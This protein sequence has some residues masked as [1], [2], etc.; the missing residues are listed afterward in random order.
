MATQTTRLTVEEFHRRYDGLKPAFEY[1]D[2]MAVQKTMPATLHGLVQFL[3][4]RLLIE[5]G[6]FAAGEV[7]LKVVPNYEPVPDVIASRR[8]FKGRYPVEAPELCIE[9]LSPEDRLSPAHLKAE[10]YLPWGTQYVWLIDP[11]NRLAWQATL[12]ED[13]PFLT[14][15]EAILTAGE[16]ALPLAELWA[17]V[18]EMVDSSG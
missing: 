10:K 3:L 14:T 7:R 18:D 9:I 5:R 4:M 13:R 8:K 17:A 1:W 12:N 15:A 6:W 2:G 11:E 16:T